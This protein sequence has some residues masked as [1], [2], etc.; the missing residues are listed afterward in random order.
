MGRDSVSIEI[1]REPAIVF[2]AIADVTRMGEWSPEC[3][4]GRWA[5][6]ATGP[7]PGAEFEGDNRV[8]LL[9]ATLKRWTTTSK[10]TE[11]VPGKVFAFVTEDYT[12]W[13]YDLEPTA[14]GTRITESYDY[15]TPSGL[16]GFVYEKVVRRASAM[17]RGMRRT[18]ER[19]KQTIEST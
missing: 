19:L 13:H 2:D 5:G 12:T 8:A 14:T 17:T 4:G 6:G 11:C 18:L 7:A 9:G 15:A 10:V 1:D 3:T 16:Q